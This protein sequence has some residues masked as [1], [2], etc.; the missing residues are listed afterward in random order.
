[1]AGVVNRAKLDDPVTSAILRISEDG[2]A[3][4]VER[5]FA[6]IA[7]RS[8]LT[9]DLVLER[10]RMLLESGVVRR[11]R[12]TLSTQN[13]ASGALVAWQVPQDDLHAA[14][15]HLFERDPFSGHVVIRSTDGALR[16]S[17]FR[18]WTT[19]KVPQGYSLGRHVE[20]LA[21]RIGA[22]GYRIMPA[23]CLFALGVGH[24]RR[25]ELLPGSRAETIAAPAF[26]MLTKLSESE[27]QVLAV[28]KEPLALDEIVELP[29]EARAAR[30]GL[31]WD[32]LRPAVE[33]LAKRGLF[34][35][36]STFLE[37]VKPLSTGERVTRYNALFHWAVE[38]GTE[39]AAGSEVG[40]HHII[41]HAYWREGG[42]EFGNVNVMAVAHGTDK[43][44]VLDH[45][46]A[47]DAHLAE[48]GIKVSY[49][50]VFWGGRSEIKPSEVLPSAYADWCRSEG[51]DPEVMREEGE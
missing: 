39:V 15:D 29:W 2:L 23:R 38:P 14:F 19:V 9:E 3:G 18:L 16:G 4:F 5:P 11:V 1:M 7:N 41:T 28:V 10:V 8:G 24:M 48:T 37:H 21:G 22:T 25:R 26:P 30:F 20:T 51:I 34:G 32:A 27:W 47:I 13:L 31:D 42:P 33:R 17:S 43:D 35:R 36:F 40:R 45:K 49:T 44:A 12:L 50:A 6:E 46:T